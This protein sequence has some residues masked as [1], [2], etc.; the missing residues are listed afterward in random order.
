MNWLTKRIIERDTEAVLKWAFTQQKPTDWM[1]KC[2]FAFIDSNGKK[3]YK[4]KDEHQMPL[5]RFEQLNIYIQEYAA[6]IDRP[7]IKSWINAAND[8]LNRKD[9]K[10][11]KMEMGHLLKSLES[12][13]DLLFEPDILLNIAMCQYI[14]EDEKPDVWDENLQ[15]EKV[16]QISKDKAAGNAL[17]FFFQEAGL[18]IYLPPL[19]NMVENW[20]LYLGNVKAQKHLFAGMMAM[21]G[22]ILEPKS[23]IGL[24]AEKEKK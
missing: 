11:L 24:K 14:R 5:N 4:Y 8:V 16:A 21:V 2:D 9:D 12:R 15:K 10:R 23:T 3:Y 7:T 22:K 13:C 19:E 20:S 17:Y 6:R 18:N 1:S